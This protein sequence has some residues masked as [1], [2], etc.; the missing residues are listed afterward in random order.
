MR[1]EGTVYVNDRLKGL[2]FD[3]L[4][5]HCQRGEVSHKFPGR[6]LL[7]CFD[8][9]FSGLI[10]ELWVT[11]TGQ[12]PLACKQAMELKTSIA[13]VFKCMGADFWTNMPF[14]T[15]TLLHEQSLVVFQHG[16]FL[17][18]VK[19]LANVAALPG[20]VKVRIFTHCHPVYWH[21][22]VSVSCRICPQT[23]EGLLWNPRRI[24][25]NGDVAGVGCCCCNH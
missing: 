6:L 18:A 25:K 17:P 20:I 19:Q 1:V 24:F 21:C 23:P 12:V 14:T 7:R 15:A 16:G 3:E 13:V 4:Q 5:Q 10:R 8:F 9:L 2:L 11:E 22:H